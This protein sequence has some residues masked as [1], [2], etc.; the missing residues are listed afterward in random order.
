MATLFELK[1]HLRNGGKIRR[2]SWKKGDWV[3]LVDSAFVDEDG[4]DYPSFPEY[5]FDT[6]WEV[7]EEPKKKFKITHTGLYKTR[8]GRKA[9]VS[10]EV[11]YPTLKA[12]FYG[13]VEGSLSTRWWAKDGKTLC[14]ISEDEK[15]FD[16]VSEWED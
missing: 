4:L 12:P 6:D 5:A 9:F 10:C 16:I 8:K 3:R 11:K 15:E 7:Y 1:E 2:V 13:L 14:D